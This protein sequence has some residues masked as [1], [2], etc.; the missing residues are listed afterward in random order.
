[1][2]SRWAAHPIHELPSYRDITPEDYEGR[3]VD[4]SVRGPG[5]L[6]RK[7]GEQRR[8]LQDLDGEGHLRLR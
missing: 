3:Q 2:P 7:P 4:A 8:R 5:A 1:L 6:A